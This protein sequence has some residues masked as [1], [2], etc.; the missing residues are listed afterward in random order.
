[1]AFP[2]RHFKTSL[3]I[4]TRLTLSAAEGVREAVLAAQ[5]F[6]I[7]SRWMFAAELESGEVVSVL[8]DWT[9]PPMDLWVIC[10]SGRLTS[11]KAHAF[12]KWFE[13]IVAPGK[14]NQPR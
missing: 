4:Q 6:A 8:N 11:T 5:G 9:L 14:S 13:K 10:P 7:S 1:M 12:V 2:S 3:R